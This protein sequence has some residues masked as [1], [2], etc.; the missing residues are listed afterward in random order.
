A[1]FDYVMDMGTSRG[2]VAEMFYVRCAVLHAAR[3]AGIAAY[4]VDWSD[5]NNEEGFLKE[6]QLAKGLGLNGKSLV[7]PRQIELLHQ[8]YSPTR[9]EVEHAY[10][11]IA[12]A[13]ESES[14]GLGVVSLN[15]HMMY[16]PIIDHPRNVVALA[17]YGTRD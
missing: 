5:I 3:V 10:E 4:D 8:A 14:R 1:A 11:V 7:N 13:E 15:G 12:A 17:S 9:K 16:G 2:D 6:V